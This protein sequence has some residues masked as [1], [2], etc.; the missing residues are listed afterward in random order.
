MVEAIYTDYY[1][2]GGNCPEVGPGIS[3]Q[4]LTLPMK[5][6]TIHCLGYSKYQKSAHKQSLPSGGG[7]ACSD[8]RL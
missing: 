1:L 5:G 3:G 2:V 4:G 6:L 8:R 7:L